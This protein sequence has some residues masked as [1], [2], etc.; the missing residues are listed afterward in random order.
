[1]ALFTFPSSFR[2]ENYVDLSTSAPLQSPISILASTNYNASEA[3]TWVVTMP[4]LP[5]VETVVR[6]LR[7]ELLGSKIAAV[8]T[9]SKRLRTP[10][11]RRSFHRLIGQAFTSVNRRGKWII[12]ALESD[13]LLVHLGMT[14]R[15]QV[16]A[17]RSPRG[18]HC[19]V[20]FS[21]VPGDRELRFCDPRRFGALL[22]LPANLALDYLERQLGPE[23]F[24]LSS[25]ELRHRLLTTKRAI[26]V[27]L[28]DQRLLAGLG[29]IYTDEALY[30][31]R[32]PPIRQA[33][34]L[35]H[36]E[37]SRLL[38]AIHQVL[39]RAI[40]CHGSSIRDYMFGENDRGTYQEE[41]L[42]YNRENQPCRRCR[43]P[44]RRIRIANR[45]CYFCP[46]CQAPPRT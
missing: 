40:E 9:S 4:E 10:L 13:C 7:S 8:R 29:N 44:I 27:A 22:S 12:L 35:S 46:N 1:M 16:V 3:T 24:A 26:K 23:P 34:T 36:S 21:L 5:E 41:F 45:S 37:C 31:A 11:P 28:M 20:V 32:I 43:H 39:N 25:A 42:V 30:Q 18:P 15:L 6:C 2:L 19:H 17:H 14:G 33:A 38:R